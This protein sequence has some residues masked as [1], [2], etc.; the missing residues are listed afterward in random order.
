MTEL[1][2][3]VPE[4]GETNLIA[5]PRTQVAFEAIRTFLNTEQLSSGNLK[6]HGIEESRLSTAVI[7]L[8][9]SKALGLSLTVVTSSTT[10]ESG[11]LLVF[12][13][14][15]G[16]TCTLPAPTLNRVVG[17][18]SGGLPVVNVATGG[19]ARIYGDFT[20]LVSSVVLAEYQ[21]VLL[22]ADG[23]N[24]LIVAGEPRR[25]QVYAEKSITKAEAETGFIPSESRTCEVKVTCGETNG[26]TK[27]TLE[28]AGQTVG[29]M[30]IPSNSTT[31]GTLSAKVNPG[32]RWKLAATGAFTICNVHTLTE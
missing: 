9:G 25:E 2:L 15:S 13:E 14:H 10:A 29:T 31:E 17:V 32:Q 23:A 27:F 26:T 24:W 20:K 8:L 19:S 30:I 5:D 6:E 16:A 22:Q 7:S 12:A 28:V 1:K 3:S 21:H 18:A 4:V 11:Q